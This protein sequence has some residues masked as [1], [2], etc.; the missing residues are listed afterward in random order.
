MGRGLPACPSQ[1]HGMPP[2]RRA[3]APS[4]G[5]LSFQ[6]HSIVTTPYKQSCSFLRSRFR[7]C[8][9]TFSLHANRVG[10]GFVKKWVCSTVHL[11]C[12]FPII[13]VGFFHL[14]LEMTINNFGRLF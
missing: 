14:F 10:G 1:A 2:A 6:P 11:Y 3:Y 12:K 7:I 4:N 8:H 9:R 13:Y 5:S